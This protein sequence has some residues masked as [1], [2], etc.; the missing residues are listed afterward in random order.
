MADLEPLRYGLHMFC[1]LHNAER[2]CENQ[3]VHT[4][5][6][7]TAHKGVVQSQVSFY[8]MV[9]SQLY[10]PESKSCTPTREY[11]AFLANI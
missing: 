9:Q 1:S 3:R 7:G 11:K 10:S 6:S 5:G 8:Q 4:K 2:E